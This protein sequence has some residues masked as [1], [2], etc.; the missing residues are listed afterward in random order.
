MQAVAAREARDVDDGGANPGA[1]VSFFRGRFIGVFAEGATS[2]LG[3]DSLAWRC[4]QSVISRRFA[5][6]PNGHTG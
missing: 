2:A 3:E 6:R 4:L 1:V 5:G